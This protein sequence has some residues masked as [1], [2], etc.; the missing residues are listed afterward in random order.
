[1]FYEILHKK[2]QICKKGRSILQKT[3]DKRF[4]SIRNT[5]KHYFIFL[6]IMRMIFNISVCCSGVIA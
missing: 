1:M 5:E 4:E 2:M 3:N 6:R